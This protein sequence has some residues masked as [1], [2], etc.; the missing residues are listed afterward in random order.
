MT[1]TFA[2]VARSRPQAIFFRSRLDFIQHDMGSQ[3]TSRSA[4][5][6]AENTDS[7]QLRA[8]SARRDGMGAAAASTGA[9]GDEPIAA[10]MPVEGAMGVRDASAT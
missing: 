6:L 5:E 7:V 10:V 2:V 4:H 1:E 8:G 3:S 9:R